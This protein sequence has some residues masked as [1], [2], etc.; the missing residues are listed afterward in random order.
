MGD[1][2]ARLR[3]LFK[4]GLVMMS[5]A[6]CWPAWLLGAGFTGAGV[7]LSLVTAGL[8]LLEGGE[9]PLRLGV[10]FKRGLVWM[11]L[12]ACWPGW[13]CRS[14]FF[15][16]S[17]LAEVSRVTLAL[18]QGCPRRRPGD[19]GIGELSPFCTCSL[20]SQRRDEAPRAFLLLLGRS[21]RGR[22]SHAH[23]TKARA[24]TMTSSSNLA[25]STACM[26]EISS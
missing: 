9:V 14:C 7:G 6:A 3:V 20:G 25:S 26:H 17:P 24:K 15:S 11:S 16:S 21:S 19:L 10:L 4:R 5:F 2:S 13:F 1:L 12:G 8:V 22:R 23:R 18:S